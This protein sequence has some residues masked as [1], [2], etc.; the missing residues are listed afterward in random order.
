MVNYN[1]FINHI[2]KFKYA[3]L[4]TIKNLINKKENNKKINKNIQK[5]EFGNFEENQKSLKDDLVFILSP[6]NYID[7]CPNVIEDCLGKSY[8]LFYFAF[9]VQR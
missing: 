7:N 4:S 5:G 1:E 6:F 8:S 2:S 9:Q 3:E